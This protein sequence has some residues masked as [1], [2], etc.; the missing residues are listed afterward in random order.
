MRPHQTTFDLGG[1]DLP[2]WAT[3]PTVPPP[4]APD[5]DTAAQ[6]E[7]PPTHTCRCLRCGRSSIGGPCSSLFCSSRCR[8]SWQTDMGRWAD[9]LS[10]VP[11][12][13]ANQQGF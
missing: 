8:T 9:R 7:S 3:A 6:A 2:L 5:C 1:L 13:G 12:E 4:S 11:L 10:N